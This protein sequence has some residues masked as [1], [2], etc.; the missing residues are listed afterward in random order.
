MRKVIFPFLP[1][2]IVY[3]LDVGVFSIIWD[4]K[5]LE[6][7]LYTTPPHHDDT[8]KSMSTSEEDSMST[9]GSCVTGP[10]PFYY[11]RFM[12][13][14]INKPKME[15]QESLAEKMTKSDLMVEDS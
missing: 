10:E 15:K 2:F 11:M 6:Q 14:P 13:A 5:T 1:C 12:P 3:V 4:A 9:S 7:R 8:N